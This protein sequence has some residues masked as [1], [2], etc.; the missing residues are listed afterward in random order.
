MVKKPNGDTVIMD[1]DG[2]V[3]VVD[4]DNQVKGKDDARFKVTIDF[5]QNVVSDQQTGNTFPMSAGSKINR[6][7]MRLVQTVK[8]KH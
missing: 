5:A 8:Q 7:G 6:K 1:S 3:V 2:S 4:R